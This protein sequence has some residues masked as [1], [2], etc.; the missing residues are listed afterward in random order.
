MGRR[1]F[2]VRAESI[3]PVGKDEVGRAF[4]TLVSAFT[5]DPVIRWLYPGARQYETHF[6][7]LLAGLGGKAFAHETVWSLGA[8]SAVALWLPPGEEPDGD[9]IVVALTETVS[10][11]QQEDIFAVVDQMG[12]AHPVF[13]HWYLP[14]FGVHDALQGKGLGGQLMRHCLAI[15]DA[16]H[17]PA[18]LETPN[19]RNI[20]FYERHGF[21]VTGEARAGAC[22]P[23]AFMLRPA[24]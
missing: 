4:D 22:P 16:S 2:G 20:S 11:E 18:Y 19:P 5:Y 10:P 1:V 12:E 15:V 7:A 13:P 6:P 9:A 8:F 3:S 21:E 14:W 17:L 23:L 24:Q